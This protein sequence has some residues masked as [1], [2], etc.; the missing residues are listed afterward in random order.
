MFQAIL[1]ILSQKIFFAPLTPLLPPSGGLKNKD[2]RLFSTQGIVT[3]SKEGLK[4]KKVLKSCAEKNFPHRRVKLTFRGVGGSLGGQFSKFW[5]K[6]K[7]P[8]LPGSGKVIGLA[9]IQSHDLK[10]LICYFDQN[11]GLSQKIRVYSIS[12]Y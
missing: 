8:S 3:K 10:F 9:A 2:N 1:S 11:L 12:Q 6:S 7:S 5:S 4:C